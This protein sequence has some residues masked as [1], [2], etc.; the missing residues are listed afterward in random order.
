MCGLTGHH[1]HNV[2]NAV[3]EQEHAHERGTV[4]AELTWFMGQIVQTW[5]ARR[6]IVWK[7]I[8]RVR[9]QNIYRIVAL[10][11]TC[12]IKRDYT[13]LTLKVLVTTIDALGH[14]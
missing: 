11:A 8:V 12:T 10:V 6:K 4:S 13:V 2:H 14:F 5:E 1:G 7:R 3:E 9:L